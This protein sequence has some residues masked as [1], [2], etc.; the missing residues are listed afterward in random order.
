MMDAASPSGRCLNLACGCNKC[1]FV[2]S[3]KREITGADLGYVPD[4]PERSQNFVIETSRGS[5][6]FCMIKLLFLISYCKYCCTL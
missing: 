1:E 3:F 6:W 2:V 5:S 4:V